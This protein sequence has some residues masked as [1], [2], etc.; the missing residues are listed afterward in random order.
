MENHHPDGKYNPLRTVYPTLRNGKKAT[1]FNNLVKKIESIVKKTQ[2]VI[3][4]DEKE[5]RIPNMLK[6]LEG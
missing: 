4:E 3:E 6:Q 2:K 5:N 1:G